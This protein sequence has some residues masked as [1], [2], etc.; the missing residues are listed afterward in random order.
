MNMTNEYIEE[1]LDRFLEGQ[2]TEA[3]ELKLK[4]F[5]SETSDIDAEWIPFRDLFHSFATDAYE[6]SSEE[7]DA[8]LMPTL[9]GTMPNRSLQKWISAACAAAVIA[10]AVIIPWHRTV[11]TQFISTAELMETINMLVEVGP[12]DMTITASSRS[13]GFV[14]NARYVDGQSDAYMLK[15]GTDGSTIELTSLPNK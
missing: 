9:T 4:E 3:E 1:L 15:R 13:K 12:D 14:V 5:F 10:L 8:L 2:T 6:L 7:L 11:K